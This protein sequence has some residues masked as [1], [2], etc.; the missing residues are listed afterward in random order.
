MT[1][2]III[3]RIDFIINS[4]TRLKD[5]LKKQKDSLLKEYLLLASERI[6]EEIVESA[7]SINQEILNQFFDH[8]SNSYYESFI[9]LKKLET[10]TEKELLDLAKTAGFRNRLAHDYLELNPEITLKSIQKILK[11]Y[12]PYLQKIQQFLQKKT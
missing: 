12:P 4:L 6:A 7:I 8:I 5:V 3:K 1:Q 9:D 11:I 10:F 2:H